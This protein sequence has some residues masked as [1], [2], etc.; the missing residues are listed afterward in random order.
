M[1]HLPKLLVVAGLAG[2]TILAVS[3]IDAPRQDDRPKNLKILPKNISTKAL[4]TIMQ[5]YSTA[6]GVD[7]DFCHVK[8]I[9]LDLKYEKDDKPE[10]LITRKMM[11]MTT[12][13][14]KKHFQYTPKVVPEAIQPV[15]CYTC[16]RGK[17]RPVEDTL[18]IK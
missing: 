8:N 10:K 1:K 14:N 9:V 2:L 18:V 13:I 7:C 17:A 5:I 11:V 6:L 4:D 12:D 16:H 15:T 3:A